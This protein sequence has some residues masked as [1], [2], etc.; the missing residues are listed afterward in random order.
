[1]SIRQIHWAMSHDWFIYASTNSV[2][3]R[4]L[5]TVKDDMIAGSTMQ[6]YSYKA[7]REWAGY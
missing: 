7:L 2:T 3:G 4:R 1:M 6:F 5:V